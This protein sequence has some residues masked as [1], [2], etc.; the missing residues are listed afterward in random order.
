MLTRT[1][2][3]WLETQLINAVVRF[4]DSRDNGDE[5]QHEY[6]AEMQQFEA[7]LDAGRMPRH[8]APLFV[9]ENS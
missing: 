5:D 6:A 4:A 1:E 9:A 7:A 3:N 2:Q 8:L